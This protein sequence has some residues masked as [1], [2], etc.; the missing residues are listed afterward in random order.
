[1]FVRYLTCRPYL[2]GRIGVYLFL[3]NVFDWWLVVLERFLVW[4]RVLGEF[5]APR[6]R[7][8]FA[9]EIIVVFRVALL[10]FAELYVIEV[11][12]VDREERWLWLSIVSPGFFLISFC[13][14]ILGV[15]LQ[16]LSIVLSPFVPISIL[17]LLHLIKLR[18]RQLLLLGLLLM[19]GRDRQLLIRS[20][21][22]WFFQQMD[23]LVAL[24]KSWALFY[25]IYLLLSVWEVHKRF[26]LVLRG[27]FRVIKVQRGMLPIISAFS[28]F[29]WFLRLYSFRHLLCQCQCQVEICLR[30]EIHIRTLISV[31]LV[32]SWWDN[33]NI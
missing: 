25:L 24:V 14:M 20:R 21:S 5:I 10:K 6:R 4:Q 22:C 19:R 17:L 29:K 7:W 33:W 32:G 16:E 12:V 27:N 3:L 9:E 2:K 13:K 11:W 31:G 23:R 28:W 8:R 15:L 30:A 18:R 1:M 26:N